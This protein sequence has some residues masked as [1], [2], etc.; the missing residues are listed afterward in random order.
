VQKVREAANRIKCQNN[1]KQI[2]VAAHHYHDAFHVFPPAVQ[3]ANPPNTPP[4]RDIASAYRTPSFGPNWAVY[5][6]PYVEQDNLYKQIPGGPQAYLASNGANQ[7]WRQIAGT[8]IP[9]FFCPADDKNQINFNLNLEFGPAGGWARGN[10]A[11]NAGAGWFNWTQNGL[12]HDG[13]S[14]S[15]THTNNV[16]GAFCINWGATIPMISNAD[17]TANTI[18]FNE[19]R[20]GLVPED[21]R[22]VWAMGL[23]A[24]SVTAANAIGDC[25]TPNDRNELSDDTEDCGLFWYPGIGSRDRIGCSRDNAPRNWPNWQGQARSRHINGVNSCFVD[26]SVRFVPDSVPQSIW[27]LMLSRDDGQVYNLD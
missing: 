25:T 16:G 18:M 2:G 9:L 11:A 24:C 15:G 23:A 12:S 14:T 21:R 19:V 7:S 17:G 3:I 27:R 1:L 10:Y 4:F 20:A 8:P 5:L 26:G 13:S 6:L 22:G